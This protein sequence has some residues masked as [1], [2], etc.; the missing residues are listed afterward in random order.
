[1][2]KEKVFFT[3]SKCSLYQNTAH[4]CIYFDVKCYPVPLFFHRL[5]MLLFRL[6]RCGREPFYPVPLLGYSINLRIHRWA[7][8]W[9]RNLEYTIT[10]FVTNYVRSM[11]KGNV[12][13]PVCPSVQW[14]S[15]FHDALAQ[16]GRRPSPSGWKKRVVRRAH[17]LGRK[18]WS[19]RSPPSP[20]QGS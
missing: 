20:D 15:L 4:I 18:D 19:G 2:H 9:F 1:M 11:R 14:G 5:Y 16:V 6:N 3:I 17:V 7:T 8:Y 10:C 12:C 13:P